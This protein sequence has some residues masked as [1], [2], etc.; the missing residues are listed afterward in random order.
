V[1]VQRNSLI[2]IAVS[3]GIVVVLG[4]T[5][6][7][8]VATVGGFAVRAANSAQKAHNDAKPT[9]GECWQTTLTDAENRPDWEDRPP[10]DCT[11]PHQLYTFAVEPLDPLYTG[12][13]YTKNGDIKPN[14]WKDA[15]DRCGFDDS[16]DFPPMDATEARI[17]F[18]YYVPDEAAWNSGARWVRCDLGLV[19]VG[20]SFAHPEFE[21]L[22][23]IAALRQSLS[24]DPGQFDLCLNDPGEP[25]SDGPEYNDAVYA[26]CADNPQW[27]LNSYVGLDNGS[28]DAYPSAAD[29]QLVYVQACQSQFTD[30]THA[31]YPVFPSSSDWMNSDRDMECWVGRT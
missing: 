24:A 3:A 6:S 27:V 22:E 8:C 31:T 5:L 13:L 2:R 17:R 11:V 10:V 23:S 19:G 30:G 1:H 29:L 15:G 26:N 14:I 7:G 4:V 18:E 21:N 12:K 25:L 20:S 28:S 9:K 16:F